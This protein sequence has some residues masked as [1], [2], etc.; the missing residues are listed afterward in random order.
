ME[1]QDI[2]YKVARAGL[3]HFEEPCLSGTRGSGTVFFSGCNLRCA[4]CQN[5]EISHGGKGLEIGED[6]LVFIFEKLESMGAHNI[7]LVT[8][9]RY[10]NLLVHTLKIAK[11]R[12]KVPI[13]WNSSGFESVASIKKLE[14]LVDV[15][16]P[17]FKYSN[18]DMAR[19]YSR[20]KGYFE[21]ASA[22]IREMRRQQPVD[23]FDEDGMMKKGVIVRHLV[24]PRG[25]ENARGVFR[26]IARIDKNMYVSVMGQ[27]F[28]TANVEGRDDLGRRLLDEEYD[29]ATEAFFE[30]GLSNGFC[31][32]LSS[33][34]EEYV[35]SFDLDELRLFLTR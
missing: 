11:S 20:A 17:D 1:G 18:D 23:Q 21:V 15:Y 24:L 4:F 26:E 30:E 19:D 13:V 9:S 35:P 29:G 3:H 31:Q 34:T 25:V 8:P 28:P 32:E 12:L 7:N 16:L 2:K 6:D 5:Y 22:A 33:A 27:Y 10:V 14:G